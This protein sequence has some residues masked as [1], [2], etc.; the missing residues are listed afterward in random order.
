MARV[1]VE[2]GAVEDSDDT[3]ELGR[4]LVAELVD[5]PELDDLELVA[6]DVSLYNSRLIILA[7]V[8]LKG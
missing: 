8:D 4:T 6:A 1:G 2:V 3:D 5:W 7:D